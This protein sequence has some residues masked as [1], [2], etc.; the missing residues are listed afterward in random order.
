MTTLKPIK[1][2]PEDFDKIEKKIV[3]WLRSEI[4]LPLIAILGRKT[5]QN[6]TEDLLDAIRSERIRFN[7]GAFDGRFSARVS[8]ELKRMG[9]KFKSGKWRIHLSGLPIDVQESIRSTES[10]FIGTLDRLDEKLRQILPEEITDKLKL[11]DQFD[12]TLFKLDKDFH[13][14]MKGIRVPAELTRD[15]R[16]EIADEYTNNLRLYIKDWTEKEISELRKKMQTNVFTGNRYEGMI[17]T[18]QKSYGVGQRKAKFLARQETNLLMAKFKTTRYTDSG[19]THYKWRAVAGSPLHPVRPRHKELDEQ[20]KAGKLFRFD[21]PP[22]MTDGHKKN[23]GEDY[24]C[25]CTAIPVV[26]F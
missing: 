6:S 18:I 5:I 11:S 14:T 1:E 25:R 9:A 7:A 23:P 4:Y 10:R 20:S 2:T 15:R 3:E 13:A 26:N 22:M 16:R 12:T 17:K 19:V 24:N 21:D 8:K